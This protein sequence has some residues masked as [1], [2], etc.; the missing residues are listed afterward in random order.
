[1]YSQ[2]IRNEAKRII[3]T[4]QFNFY[5]IPILMT[6]IHS[7]SSKVFSDSFL[8]GLLVTM[9]FSISV[10]IPEVIYYSAI[11]NGAPINYDRDLIGVVEGNYWQYISTAIL[12]QVYIMLWTLLFIIPG[13]IKQYS[14]AVVPYILSDN[15]EMSANEA[16]QKSRWLMNG[17]K[18]DL[19]K[20]TIFYDVLVFLA[21][22]LVLITGGVSLISTFRSLFF[23]PSIFTGLS[24]ILT[25]LSLLILQATQV[26]VMPYKN[27]ATA[28]FYIDNFKEKKRKTVTV[29]EE[30]DEHTGAPEYNEMDFLKD[31]YME[32]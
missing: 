20:I 25:L 7:V 10:M 30:T 6:I 9:V 16:I 21:S 31:E 15:P 22:L 12:R 29:I 13:I 2:K 14:Y 3:K 5:L 19:F 27:T 1:M 23:L 26:Y 28:L 11:N 8:G 4:D 18:M 17:Y 24:Y 32:I